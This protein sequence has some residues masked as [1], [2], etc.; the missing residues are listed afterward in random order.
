MGGG[1]EVMQGCSGG[2]HLLV[3]GKLV[4]AQSGCTGTTVFSGRHCRLI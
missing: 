4:E 2:L 1:G 3:G